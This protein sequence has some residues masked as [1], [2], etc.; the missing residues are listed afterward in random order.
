MKSVPW[1]LSKVRVLRKKITL[2]LCSTC[3]KVPR[4][5][6]VRQQKKF[7]YTQVTSKRVLNL[8]ESSAQLVREA[9]ANIEQCQ[10]VER[11]FSAW[12]QTK[13]NTSLFYLTNF[14][15]GLIPIQTLTGWYEYNKSVRV[16]GNVSQRM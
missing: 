7:L 12:Q 5:S 1:Y 2:Q 10:E 8:L 11:F 16:C 14:S 9:E 4:S 6:F 13:M 15:V 3:W